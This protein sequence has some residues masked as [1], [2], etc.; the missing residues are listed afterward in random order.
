M[1]SGSPE[2][3][4]ADAN[5]SYMSDIDMSLKMFV[6]LTGKNYSNNQYIC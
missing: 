2:L 5:A 4:I 6:H 1:L 3:I